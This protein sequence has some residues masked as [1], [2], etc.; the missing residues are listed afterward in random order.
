MLKFRG[1]TI[2]MKKKKKNQL[3]PNWWLWGVP[4][5]GTNRM[6]PPPPGGRTDR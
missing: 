6:F 3:S 5:P 2:R 1:A 4:C